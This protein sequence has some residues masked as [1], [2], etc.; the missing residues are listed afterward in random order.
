MQ[1]IKFQKEYVKNRLDEK[2][3]GNLNITPINKP[4]RR[5]NTIYRPHKKKQNQ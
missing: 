2:I 4:I 3:M 1:I 5:L